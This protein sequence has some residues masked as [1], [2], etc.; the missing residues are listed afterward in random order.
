[1]FFNSHHFVRFRKKALFV[2]FPTVC[3]IFSQRLIL[4]VLQTH[5]SEVFY[6]DMNKIISLFSL[7]SSMISLLTTFFLGKFLLDYALLKCS[8]FNIRSGIYIR[9]SFLYFFILIMKPRWKRILFLL[10]LYN[11]LYYKLF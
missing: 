1:M 9:T 11:P 10:C 4:M 2:K 5:T 7:P 6:F 8:E 3:L